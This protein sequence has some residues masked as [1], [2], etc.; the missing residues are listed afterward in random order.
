MRTRGPPLVGALLA[1]IRRPF[2][3]MLAAQAEYGDIYT[4]DLGALQMILLNHPRHVEH[5]LVSNSRNYQ[6]VRN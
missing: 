4:L 1:F 3:F 5:V 6:R 2:E